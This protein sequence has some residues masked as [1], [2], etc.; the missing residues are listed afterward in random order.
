MDFEKN[1]G[2]NEKLKTEIEQLNNDL[3]EIFHRVKTLSNDFQFKGGNLA[4][5]MAGMI[6]ARAGDDLGKV[7]ATVND[8]SYQFTK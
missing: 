3:Y 8:M 2:E 6:L 1:Y 5:R 4:D 7:C